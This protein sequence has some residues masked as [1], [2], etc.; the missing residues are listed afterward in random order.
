MTALIV[1]FCILLFLLLAALLRVSVSINYESEEI[2]IKGKI[3][4]V[5]LSIYPPSEKKRQQKKESKKKAGSS[6]DR[7]KDKDKNVIKD[8]FDSVPIFLEVF[9]RLRRTVKVNELSLHITVGGQDPFDTAMLYGHVS[10]LLGTLTPLIDR[11]FDVKRQDVTADVDFQLD[12]SNIIAFLKFSLSL[13][14]IIYIVCA[15]LPLLGSSGREQKIKEVD[16][17]G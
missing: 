9:G 15:L 3:G 13:W 14:E 17:H 8:F 5:S 4:P 6:S 7:E 11:T 12:S 2:R 16:K 1:I 10:E